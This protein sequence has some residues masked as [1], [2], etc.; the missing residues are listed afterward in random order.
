MPTE[1]LLCALPELFIYYS[2][3]SEMSQLSLPSYEEIE[4]KRFSK[5]EFNVRI[6]PIRS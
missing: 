5:L 6:S 2:P 4:T 3:S 1:H